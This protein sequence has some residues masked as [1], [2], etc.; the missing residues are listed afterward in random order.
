MNNNTI[1]NLESGEYFVRIDFNWF[2]PLKL[3]E[4]YFIVN[5]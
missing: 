2:L 1:L 4:G 3:N 5:S